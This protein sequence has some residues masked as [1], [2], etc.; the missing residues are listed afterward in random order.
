[1]ICGG[2]VVRERRSRAIES[3]DDGIEPSGRYSEFGEYIWGLQMIDLLRHAVGVD[4]ELLAPPDAAGD[5]ET[6]VDNLGVPLVG[7][8][9]GE[10]HAEAVL[11]A[12]DVL[13]L[14][15]A[16]QG[17]EDLGGP[18]EGAS[19]A[20]LQ[21][22]GQSQLPFH[23]RNVRCMNGKTHVAGDSSEVCMTKAPST[24]RMGRKPRA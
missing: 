14:A 15:A 24:M 3:G 9:D 12:V 4:E 23:T 8:L 17:V 19:G 2:I 7:R 5:P 11:A 20:H 13:W 18:R 1:M 10:E 16:E 22:S 21:T 6:A